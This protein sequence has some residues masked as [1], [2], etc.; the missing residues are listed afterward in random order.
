[1]SPQPQPSI[2]I[3]IAILAGGKSSRMGR[4]KS[5]VLLAGRSLLTHARTNAEK[6]GLPVR[7]IREDIIASCGP[8]SG[9]YTALHSSRTDAELFLACDMPFVSTPL[10]QRLLAAFQP[11]DKACFVVADGSAGFPFIIRRNCADLIASKIRN[12]QWSLQALAETLQARAVELSPTEETALFNIN[13]PADLE[14]ARNLQ[15]PKSPSP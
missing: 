11:G 2:S 4:E 8:L 13:T 1:M 12:G 7:V 14:S 10:L 3:G 5:R 6:L 9:I 15:P